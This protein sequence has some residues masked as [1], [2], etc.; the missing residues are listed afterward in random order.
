MLSCVLFSFMWKT[1]FCI[2][3]AHVTLDQPPLELKHTITLTVDIIFQ[4]MWAAAFSQSYSLN[5]SFSP[6]GSRLWV[7]FANPLQEEFFHELFDLYEAGMM[8]EM[9]S[10]QMFC[11]LALCFPFCFLQKVSGH[12]PGRPAHIQLYVKPGDNLSQPDVPA[13]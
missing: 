8:V 4:I 13:V 9:I 3:R 5:A 10:C 1:G 2:F 6:D 11:N 7:L 12:L